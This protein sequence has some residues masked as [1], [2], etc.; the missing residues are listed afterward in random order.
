MV[1]SLCTAT[2]C[3]GASPALNE[4]S[5]TATKRAIVALKTH[6][7]L[8]LR[9]AE[10]SDEGPFDC[11]RRDRITVVAIAPYISA[12]EEVFRLIFPKNIDPVQELQLVAIKEIKRVIPRYL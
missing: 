1:G 7:I 8:D 2:T 12:S 9:L 6:K 4:S 5:E 10:V 3:E 11:P